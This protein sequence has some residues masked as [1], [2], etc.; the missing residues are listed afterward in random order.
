MGDAAACAACARA[1]GDAEAAVLRFIESG[2]VP[3][4]RP[5]AL[6]RRVRFAALL[7]ARAWIA[8]AAALAIGLIPW[9]ATVLR[10]RAAPTE[11]PQRLADAAMLAGHFLH[12]PFAPRDPSAPPAKVVYARDGAWMYVIAGPGARPLDVAVVSADGRRS[13]VA[14]LA[15]S[16][17]T[18]SAFIRTGAPPKEVQLLDGGAP[19]ATAQTVYP[20]RQTEV[21]PSPV[22]SRG[23]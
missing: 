22:R 4:A 14:T 13:V 17:T 7:P 20:A 16:D 12:A 10:E 15:A 18:R 2:E 1:L 23:P 19:V 11:Q 21:S 5:G 9:A 6:D 8:V 3:A